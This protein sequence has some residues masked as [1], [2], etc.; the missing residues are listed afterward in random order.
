MLESLEPSF[1]WYVNESAP[2]KAGFGVYDHEPFAFNETEPFAGPASSTAV[3]G[4]P[5]T[6]VSLPRT[7]GA[8]TFRVRSWSTVKASGT[9]T[10]GELGA[11]TVMAS[12]M[13]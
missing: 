2:R 3:S 7:P 5:S 13:G 12:W 9:A 10:G 1:A 4:S 11:L 6:S 8:A